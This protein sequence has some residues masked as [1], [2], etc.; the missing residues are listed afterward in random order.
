MFELRTQKDEITISQK[1][2][3]SSSLYVADEFFQAA[4]LLRAADEQEKMKRASEARL[5][6]SMA[7]RRM[8]RASADAKATAKGL[9]AQIAALRHF[10]FNQLL[11]TSQQVESGRATLSAEHYTRLHEQVHQT[12]DAL[13]RC[14]AALRDGQLHTAKGECVQAESLLHDLRTAFELGMR[15]SEA[16][17]GLV[18][19]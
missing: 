5:L 14:A 16:K 17:S 7:A 15:L 18:K 10:L 11:Q 3:E 12:S 13:A 19:R 1:M 6:S 4:Q 2:K 9:Q 8:E